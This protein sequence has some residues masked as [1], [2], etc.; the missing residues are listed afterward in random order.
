MYH[1]SYNQEGVNM[2]DF[3]G[4]VTE[5][6]ILYE[7]EIP[8][9]MACNMVKMYWSDQYKKELHKY[10]LMLIKPEALIMGKTPEIFSI[11]H[12]TG[13]ELIYFVRKNIDATR[14]SE[15]WKFSWLNSSLERI[16]VNQKLFSV[17]D[18]LILILRSQNFGAKSACEMLTDLKGSAFESKRKPHQI[19]W[20]IRP[21]NYI[22]NYIHTSDDSNDFLREI[23]I[24]LDW[25][26][27]IQVFEAIA[28]N[29]IISYP[30]IE[31]SASLKQDYTLSNWLNNIYDKIE[32]SNLSTPDK[33]YIMKN[34]QILKS[35][36]GQKITLNFLRVL[37]QYELIKWDFETIVVLSNNINYL[38]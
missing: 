6:N 19:R 34:I 22:L 17:Y 7:N 23:G 38:K 2:F 9:R 27:L 11:L 8:Y 5:K 26:E 32:I 31:K 1:N 29:H 35:Y 30:T 25:D 20:K 14:T 15:M 10:G 12:A 21:I 4:N 28:S 16:L 18:S 37:C 33:N 36:T 24:L 3:I 13:Y